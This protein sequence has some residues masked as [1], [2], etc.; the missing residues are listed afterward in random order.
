MPSA[1]QT[2]LLEKKLVKIRVPRGDISTILKNFDKLAGGIIGGI[3]A[4]E[5]MEKIAQ[6]LVDNPSFREAFIKDVKGA[7]EKFGGD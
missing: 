3:L 2:Q 7:V 5:K 4:P 1:A 6:Q